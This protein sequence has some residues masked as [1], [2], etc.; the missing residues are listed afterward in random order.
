VVVGVL[1]TLPL[2]SVTMTEILETWP[3]SKERVAG[4]KVTVVATPALELFPPPHPEIV[5]I[6]ASGASQRRRAD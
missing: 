4:V 2:A 5:R 6:I 1:R 3:K